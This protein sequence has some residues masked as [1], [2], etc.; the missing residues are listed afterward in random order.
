MNQQL[1]KVTGIKN[2]DVSLAVSSVVS[3]FNQFVERDYMSDLNN[4]V[5]VDLPKQ[6]QDFSQIRLFKLNK[7]VINQDEDINQAL[8]NIYK[9]LY[10]LSGSCI[11]VIK[12]DG[13][14][15]ELFMGI[16]SFKQ[17][18]SCMD[19]FSGTF[20]GNFPGSE[21]DLLDT[22]QI[23]NLLL[24]SI[25]KSH[26]KTKSVASLSI[27]PSERKNGTEYVQG[28][29]RFINSMSGQE[30]TAIL[31]ASPV[32]PE[33]IT[34]KR[35]G[36]ENLH[37]GM[38]SLNTMTLQYGNST[39]TAASNSMAQSITSSIAS[40]ITESVGYFSS[41]GYTLQTNSSSGVSYNI[42]GI[43]FNNG[44]GSGKATSNMNGANTNTAKNQGVTN[45]QGTVSTNTVTSTQATN[46][47]VTLN[48]K[49]KTIDEMEKKIDRQLDRI[50]NGE[51]Y[52]FWECAA[53]F[54][55]PS[56]NTSRTAASNFGGLMAGKLSGV[57]GNYINV[58]TPNENIDNTK[59]ILTSVAY[60]IHPYV[61]IDYYG[62][63]LLTNPASFI[64]GNELPIVLGIPHKAVDSVPVIQMA[65]FGRS[66]M[67]ASTTSSKSLTS[68]ASI[69]LGS[70]YH[71]GRCENTKVSISAEALRGHC[72]ITGTNN[73]GK[74]NTTFLILD[75]L[76]RS[77]C[78]FLVIEPVKGEYKKIFGNIPG[79]QIFTGKP[80]SYRMLKINPFRFC[81]G[82]T[83]REHIDRLVDIF[84]VCWPMYS[85]MP[86][87]L[88]DCVE[89]AYIKC[90]WDLTNSVNVS[91]SHS[92]YPTLSDLLE[93]MPE[94]IDRSGYVGE[95]KG[96]FKGSMITRLKSLTTG[97]YG[98]IFSGKG[99][100]SDNELFDGKVIIDLSNV[101]ANETKSLIIGVLLIR[102]YEYRMATIKQENSPLHHVTILEE[103]HNILMR[104]STDQN[105]EHSNIKGKS[106]ELLKNI[107]AEIRSY[108]EGI[109]IVD[110]SPSEVHSAAIKNTNT[111]IIMK[112]PDK[113]DREIAA[114]SI[115]A[116]PAQS[117]E[118]SRF[119]IGVAAVYQTNWLEPIL[120]KV[121]RWNDSKYRRDEKEISLDVIKK[122][123]GILVAL[124]IDQELVKK[125]DADA[126]IHA[127]RSITIFSNDKKADYCAIFESFRQEYYDIADIFQ[128]D[129]NTR[130][131]FF[132]SVIKELMGM[133][134]FFDLN[135]LPV[136]SKSMTTPY[137]SDP[138]FIK[139][140]LKWYKKATTSLKEYLKIDKSY[141][142]EILK[143][144]LCAYSDKTNAAPSV[145][146]VVI[147]NKG[148]L[149]E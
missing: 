70:V 15:T 141:L 20:S 134:E 87:L 18:A 86:A 22:V 89:K 108:G 111:K 44:K 51:A 41:C 19:A 74:S 12:S 109:L 110:Q 142:H 37:T 59:K 52:G 28:L 97:S 146:N 63:K 125:Y 50:T 98:M 55:T 2:T 8:I 120:V 144:L 4:G 113:E 133:Y 147:E 145:Y 81:E 54:I 66:V 139:M 126:L 123:R 42:L 34:E 100:L 121:N 43:G 77:G 47:G 131:S 32:S 101:G 106:V 136:R 112:L 114:G 137:S 132:A 35:R 64:N 40:S 91:Y 143:V 17:A 21:F 30:Y 71:M 61:K 38:S 80:N 53:Y 14:K 129:R 3:C 26:G 76:H 45:A 84:N 118:I 124:L 11:I 46:S 58:W 92:V 90:G 148:F 95:T 13:N 122:A 25:N 7:I 115:S 67:L 99:D 83:V 1:Q 103:A 102:L 135:P 39:S 130:L 48:Y 88:R 127:V 75:G 33:S 6:L 105:E 29:E 93:I 62:F 36:L 104:V 73:A 79:I 107:I 96:N 57:E 16:R 117:D 49:N 94:I 82:T 72:F 85:T 27:V 60:C 23:N 68:G 119:P 149:E 140:S 78:N 69:E 31:L 10:N 128:N 138:T 24:S 116:T 9:T 56:P 5:V 65:E